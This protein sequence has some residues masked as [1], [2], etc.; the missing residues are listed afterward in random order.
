[1][2]CI[3]VQVHFSF[4]ITFASRLR[5]SIHVSISDWRPSRP[6]DC[7]VM[8]CCWWTDWQGPVQGRR[9]SNL[10]AEQTVVEDSMRPLDDW[11][12]LVPSTPDAEWAAAEGKQSSSS[13]RPN[14][15]GSIA[16]VFRST[17]ILASQSC[18]VCRMVYMVESR[19]IYVKYNKF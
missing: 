3:S 19:I 17:V 14:Q 2:I 1:M 4:T 12:F 15:E 10:G 5:S 11:R 16:F 8:M 6:V 13:R 9:A 7:H 18:L